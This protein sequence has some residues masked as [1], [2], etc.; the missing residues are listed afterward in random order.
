MIIFIYG[1]D[2]YRA[3]QKLNDIIDEF[4]KKHGGSLGLAKFDCKEKEIVS[5][6]KSFFETS[7]MFSVKKLAI[8]ENIFAS[9][10]VRNLEKLIKDLEIADSQD[11]FLVIFD[12]ELDALK[13]DKK[14]LFTLLNKKPNIVQE[15]SFFKNYSQAKPWLRSECVKLGIKEIDEKA[16]EALFSNFNKDH[17]RLIK[18]LEKLSLY[19]LSGKITKDDVAL[20]CA[21]EENPNI[22]FILDG[23]F[24]Q[25]KKKMAFY[26]K[27]AMQAD[28]DPAL[29]FNMLVNQIRA[30][31][32][33]F[34][35]QSQEIELHPYVVRKIKAQTWRFKKE[36]VLA[37]Y[38]LLANLDL[39]VKTGKIDYEMA[40]ERIIQS[41]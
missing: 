4:Q 31:V 17:W 27:Q 1:A 21:P 7:G 3:K 9:I 22:F 38:D 33:I 18:E 28:I 24:E 10:Q 13:E 19:K 30:L 35:N 40:L 36:K 12:G 26:F 32:Y 29:V 34:L 20:I 8:L 23:F 14:K 25:D 41:I 6:L 39:G 2:S 15:F 37:L 5:D 11:N 16:L